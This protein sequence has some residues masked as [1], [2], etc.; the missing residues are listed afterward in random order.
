VDFQDA[1]G[2]PT[3]RTPDSA[4][5]RLVDARDVR[6]AGDTIVPVREGQAR[7]DDLAVEGSGEFIV[8]IA[9]GALPPVRS[10][11]H[12]AV[13]PRPLLPRLRLLSGSV[14][15][16]AVDS[17]RR[18]VVVAPGAEL[19]GVLRV[20]SLTTFADA[21]MLMG[22]V[23]TWGDRRTNY[24]ALRALPSHGLIEVDVILE[25]ANQ[26]GRT[27]RAPVVPGQYRLVVAAMAETE[28][29]YIASMTNWMMGA[30]VWSDGNDVVD[31]TP[32]VFGRLD[33]DGVADSLPMLM[34]S[35]EQGALPSPLVPV[36]VAGTT[37][38]VV[39]T[40]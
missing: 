1:R 24:M 12:W 30:P 38:E 32:E 15:G 5:V 31:W 9:A 34:R 33:A 16:Q 20:R 35:V 8:E 2:R 6:L 23:A 4:R 13:G 26:P 37:I 36:R 3:A 7:F 25:D 18:R 14:A 11:R 17:T 10:D 39:V 27:L 29:R 22:V 21:A 40:R 19:G 28:M